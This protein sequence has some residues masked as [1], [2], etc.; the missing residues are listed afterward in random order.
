MYSGV[1]ESHFISVTM[2]ECRFRRTLGYSRDVFW[3]HAVTRWL[4]VY[5]VVNVASSQVIGWK[6]PREQITQSDSADRATVRSRDP[7]FHGC[8]SLHV[9]RTY[10]FPF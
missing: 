1:P 2:S 5:R 3:T 10:S 6:A 7:D 4:S 8:R 9:L